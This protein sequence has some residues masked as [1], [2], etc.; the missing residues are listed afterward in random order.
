MENT[1]STA[2]MKNKAIT[3]VG[4]EER[5][6][7][8]SVMLV[9][10][11]CMICVPSLMTGALLIEAMSLTDA[12]IASL[13]GCAIICVMISVVGFVGSDCGLPTVVLA[14]AAFGAQGA[15]IFISLV[16]A[17]TAIGWFAI[18]CEECGQAFSNLLASS[19]GINL[20]VWL[21]V[22]L[23]GIVMLLT[24]VFGFDAMEKLNVIATPLLIVASFAGVIMAVNA[25]GTGGLENHAVDPAAEMSMIDGVALVVSL[26]AFAACAA[27]DFTRYQKNRTQTVISN[28]VGIGGIGFVMVMLGAIL[29]V[30]ANEYDIS[31][32]FI[33]V[34]LPVIGVIALILATWTTNTAN[35]YSGGIDLVSL[36]DAKDEKRGILTA[37]AGGIAIVITLMGIASN[38][39]N[40]LNLLGCLTLPVT[41]AVLA[42]Y[43]II[44]KGNPKNWK[45][46]K[47]WRI[48]GFA[49]TAAGVAVTYIP[50]GIGMINGMIASII[51]M[52]IFEKLEDNIRK[53]PEQEIRTEYEDKDIDDYYA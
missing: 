20:P 44:R 35:A 37:I 27:P 5:K 11:G 6:S 2:V 32:V 3:R 22:A 33:T 52:Y 14:K 34:G 42:D 36:F 46:I 7:W 26:G 4:K 18:Q 51:A 1:K 38:F 40:T 28:S 45:Y 25:F 24:A 30:I 8:V 31:A 21:S 41:G 12:I 16:W 53:L 47:G 43:F 39:I 23:W 48:S 29:T 50:F 15:R 13:I 17:V 10:M 19:L 9:Q 49:A